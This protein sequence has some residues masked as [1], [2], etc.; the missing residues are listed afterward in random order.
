MT[1][2]FFGKQ[3]NNLYK[4]NGSGKT[5]ADY[6]GTVKTQ[7]SGITAKTI[8]AGGNAYGFLERNI[9]SN[10]K[11]YTPEVGNHVKK[12]VGYTALGTV[13]FIANAI[14]VITLIPFLPWIGVAGVGFGIYKGVKAIGAV[15]NDSTN[16]NYVPKKDRKLIL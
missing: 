9:L 8:E 14:P 7:S 1:R 3:N 15:K 10:M 11:G 4:N 5:L 12:A 16:P 6:V 13:A 2:K